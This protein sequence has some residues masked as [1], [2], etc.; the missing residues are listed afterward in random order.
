MSEVALQL[1]LPSLTLGFGIACL[2]GVML[3]LVQHVTFRWMI[4]SYGC[5]LVGIYIGTHVA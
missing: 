1:M 5:L 2:G 4:A 3:D